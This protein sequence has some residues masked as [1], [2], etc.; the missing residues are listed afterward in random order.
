MGKKHLNSVSN[1]TK[2]KRTP[3]SRKTRRSR[4]QR[5]AGN[6]LLDFMAANKGNKAPSPS[7]NKYTDFM[8]NDKEIID[9]VR[10]EEP[11]LQE[12]SI[13]KQTKPKNSEKE[14]EKRKHILSSLLEKSVA[15]YLNVVCTDSG[16]C[17]S[18][19]GENE[20]VKIFFDGFNTFKYCI[21]ASKIGDESENGFIHLLNYKRKEY[22]SCAVLKSSALS[23]AD[24]LYY[25]YLV[26][27]NFINKVNLIYPCF[28]ETYDMF[29][30]SDQDIYKKMKATGIITVDEI[31][32]SLKLI[33]KRDQNIDYFGTSCKY[34][35]NLCILIQH[36][37]NAISLYQYVKNN[38]T[39]SFFNDVDIVQILFQVYCPLSQLKNQYT[40]YDLHTQNVL[41]YKLE[42]DEYI[43]MRYIYPDGNV[44]QFNTSVIVKIID[45]GKSFFTSNKENPKNIYESI[46]QSNYC[47]ESRELCG[48]LSGYD[49][50]QHSES[51][52]DNH[53]MTPQFNNISHD[54]RLLNEMKLSGYD[55]NSAI[56]YIIKDLQYFSRYGTGQK[57]Y[58]EENKIN[59]VYDLESSLQNIIKDTKFNSLHDDFF[60]EK[61]NS[62]IGT[63]TVNIP[64][65]NSTANKQMQYKSHTNK[66]FDKSR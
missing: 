25:E 43:T 35:Q 60:K 47:N 7:I 8:T 2:K 46:C 64:S 14:F 51:N 11:K 33:P 22:K 18:F 55:P 17:L 23:N 56:G 39:Q 59:N 5:G 57:L 49:Y 29:I 42:N 12:L 24:N 3:R 54:L 52:I 38:R 36:V 37:P 61:Q 58:S 20:K 62:I 13:R 10:K 15:G 27:V 26:G 16:S 41:L 50:L 9:F 21:S 34:S 63:L 6:K 19:G 44:I 45:Y 31:K 32:S 4:R 1:K 30:N 53:F 65:V 48:N 66:L 28:L 40:H